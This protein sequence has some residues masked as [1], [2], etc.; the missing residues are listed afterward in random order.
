MQQ[1]RVAA[2]RLTL[3]SRTSSP[4]VLLMRE[5][6]S[7]ALWSS[8]SWFP[9]SSLSLQT[10][11]DDMG[12]GCWEKG[13]SCLLPSLASDKCHNGRKLKGSEQRMGL[14]RC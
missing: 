3:S 7:W 2:S 8:M 13:E 10:G 11:P 5:A 4:R 9:R 14:T 12:P 6:T 1:N